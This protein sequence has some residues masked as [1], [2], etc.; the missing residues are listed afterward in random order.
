MLYNLTNILYRI[1]D[2]QFIQRFF[3]TRPFTSTRKV[4]MKEASMRKSKHIHTYISES[5]IYTLYLN[6]YFDIGDNYFSS[7]N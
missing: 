6:Y 3:L 7:Q 1:L 4:L 5:E 2:I